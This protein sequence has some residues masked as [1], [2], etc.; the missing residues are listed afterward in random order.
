MGGGGGT[1]NPGSWLAT[2]SFWLFAYVHQAPAWEALP[3][4]CIL[5][6]SLFLTQGWPGTR[7]QRLFVD[8]LNELVDDQGLHS[9]KSAALPWV[10][11]SLPFIGVPFPFELC[12]VRCCFPGPRRVLTFNRHSTNT[13]FQSLL[14]TQT[15]IVQIWWTKQKYQQTTAIR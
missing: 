4:G 1:G 2:P 7:G 15:C 5:K 13:C 11:C 8:W 14:R 10:H 6:Q 12:F 9:G 3:A